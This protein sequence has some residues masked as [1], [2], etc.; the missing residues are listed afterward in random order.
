MIIFFAP[1]T[2]LKRPGLPEIDKI[3]F[4]ISVLDLIIV[5]FFEAQS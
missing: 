3:D 5:L 4:N 1:D 2:S